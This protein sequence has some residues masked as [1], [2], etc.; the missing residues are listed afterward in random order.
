MPKIPTTEI[1]TIIGIPCAISFKRAVI[2]YAQMTGA[3]GI[4]A[5]IRP[6]IY[7]AL[8]DLPGFLEMWKL[9]ESMLQTELDSMVQDVHD[10]MADQIKD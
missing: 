10:S 7:A 8:L 5:L 9:H 2:E 3:G 6:L 4:T 1:N